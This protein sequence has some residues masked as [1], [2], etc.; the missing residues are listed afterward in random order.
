MDDGADVIYKLGQKVRPDP[1]RPEMVQLTNLYLSEQEYE[2][3][4][5]LGGAE[6]RKVR[7]RSTGVG[8]AVGAGTGHQVVV[9]EFGGPLTGLI[10][11][12]IE[13]R[14]DQARLAGSASPPLAV[15]DVTDDDRFSGGAL[16]GTAA[17]ELRVLLDALGVAV[18]RP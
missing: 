16:A 6:I 9:D 4:T 17:D 2:V 5:R 7:R 15:A 3:L 13:L 11:A 14:P 1:D 18:P 10:L 12:E 8:A